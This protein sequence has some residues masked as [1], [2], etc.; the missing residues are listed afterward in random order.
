MLLY[1]LAIA[2]V[3][4]VAGCGITATIKFQISNLLPFPLNELS[5]SI[6]QRRAEDF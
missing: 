1:A 6:T 4:V 2:A 3:H 5:R